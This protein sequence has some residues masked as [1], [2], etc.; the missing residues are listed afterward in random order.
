MRAK[1]RSSSWELHQII[2]IQST[3][4]KPRKTLNLIKTFTRWLAENGRKMF[5]LKSRKAKYVYQHAPSSCEV[6]FMC[7]GHLIYTKWEFWILSLL[8]CVLSLK[9][10]PDCLCVLNTQG[11][12]SWRLYG[13]NRIRSWTIQTEA[14]FL[15]FTEMLC[16]IS[17][18]NCSLHWHKERQRY[19]GAKCI[20]GSICMF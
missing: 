10:L 18:C 7:D 15:C 13:W 17:L 19:V 8:I 5:D 4:W 3:Y 20:R 14:L 16:R 11:S 9:K 1:S 12:Q 2:I 6:M